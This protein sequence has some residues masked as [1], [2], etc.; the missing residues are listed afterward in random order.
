M[1]QRL[2]EAYKNLEQQNEQDF[3]EGKIELD[4]MWGKE[5]FGVFLQIDLTENVKDIMV[6]YQQALNQLEPGNLLLPPRDT[7]HVSVNQVIFWNGSYS[8]GGKETWAS[9]QDDFLEKMDGFDQ[10]TNSFDIT[11]SKLIATKN[12]I[13]WTGYDQSDELQNLRSSL[14]DKLPF[15]KETKKFNNI[16]HTTVARYK[17]RLTN[18]QKIV[19]YLKQQQDTETMRVKRIH[20]KE[21]LVFPSLKTKDIADISLR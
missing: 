19:D 20:L 4:T 14:R 13:L 15:P 7:Q 3:L 6:K 21:E 16:I 12:A 1:N 18:P 11:F 8:H 5:V 10:A 9:M 17:N 2:T